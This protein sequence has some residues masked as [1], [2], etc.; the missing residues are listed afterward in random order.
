MIREAEPLTNHFISMPKELARL[1]PAAFVAGIL[2]GMLDAASFVRGAGR[3]GRWAV[4]EEEG[5]T[6][7]ARCLRPL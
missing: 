4:V 2:H 7:G 5:G 3:G 1:N 6:P